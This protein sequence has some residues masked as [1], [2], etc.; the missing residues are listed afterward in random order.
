MPATRAPTVPQ[1]ARRLGIETPEHVVLEIELA[2]P[3]SRV[4][5]ALCDAGIL[6]I[7]LAFLFIGS[8]TLAANAGAER[9][10]G[11]L[12]AVLVAVVLFVIIWGYFLLF[13]AFNDGR[14]P[15]KRLMG[16]R[17]VMDTGHRISFTAA[18]VRNLV[19]VADA[20]PLFTYLLGFGFVLFHPQNK[21]LGDIV[22]GTIVVRDRPGDLQLAGM[23]GDRPAQREPIEA[24][25]P[26]LSDEEFRLLDQFLERVE[27][28]DVALRRRFTAELAARFAPRFPRRDPDPATFLV[29]LHASELEKRQGRLA[30]RRD[31]GV[32]RTSIAAER[33]VM[34]KRDAW[35]AFRGLA[36]QAERGGLKRLGAAAIPPFAAQ[37]REVA[38]DLARA[39]TYGV[40]PRV[41]EYLERV[42]SAGHNALYGRHTTG[43]LD[44]AR[45]LL[46]EIPA[47]VVAGRA[48]VLA[49]LIAFAVPAVTGFLLLR[50]RP[51]VAEEV[52][53]DEMIARASAGA[54]RRAEGVG[55]AEAPSMY[56][57][58]VA[59][60]II[61]NNV[62]VAFFAF[63]LGSTAGLGTLSILAMNGLFFGAVLGLFANYS[64]AGWLLTFVAGHGVL[65]LTA[66]FIAGGAGFRIA[67]AMIA[68]GDRTR[69]D[70]L[71]LEGRMAA[72]MVAASVTLLAIAG[73]IEGLLSASDAPAVFK[74]AASAASAVFLFLYLRNGATYLRVT[75]P[76]LRGSGASG[77]PAPRFASSS[78]PSPG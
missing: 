6:I 50:E 55:Y 78:P 38:A 61:T 76:D 34:R 27:D 1:F 51:A 24:G 8:G 18:A 26:E 5:A 32:G 28:L 39:R 70:A 29:V 21:R 2:G 40:D 3:G 15:G 57:P 46:R 19:R 33:F 44:V 4:A 14:T 41:I 12:M 48:Y 64:L 37:Y 71:V 13:E 73:T 65:E 31:Q 63:A 22:A 45:L 7:L 35:E 77:A 36:A 9:R 11:T 68:P 20:Q 47:A 10:W 60:R 30:A 58:V 23:P 69:R 52:L 25:P 66:I 74:F 42:V 72:R 43:R 59:S 67:G 75:G 54:E 49:A 17:V 53:P 16:I 62:Q 56:L